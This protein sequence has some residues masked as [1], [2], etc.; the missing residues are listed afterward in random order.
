MS[1]KESQIP[2]HIAEAISHLGPISTQGEIARFFKV[3]PRTI[4]RW[5]EA[6]KLEGF[7][8]G[9]EMKYTR[10]HAADLLMKGA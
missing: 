5:T 9:K 2:P 3:S 1:A 10:G 8:V 6:G 4:K 7:R